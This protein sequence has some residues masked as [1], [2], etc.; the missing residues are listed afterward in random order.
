MVGSAVSRMEGAPT[1]TC[2][3]CRQTRPLDAFTLR[4]DARYYNMCRPCVSEI[5]LLPKNKKR[6]DHSGTERTCYLCRRRLPVGS[7]TRRSNKT[8]FSACKDCNRHVF[9]QRRRARLMQ[10][11][12]SYSVQEWLALLRLFER[13]PGCLRAWT[14]I[15]PIAG[16]PSVVTVDHIVAI[17]KG[18][19]NSIGNIQ[20]LCY[21]CNSR[22][23][24][25]YQKQ[26]PKLAGP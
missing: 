26:P 7:F 18:G 23:G 3:R 21:S 20:P 12:G 22:K 4:L 25:R 2:Y 14:D 6:L 16:R 17:A 1:Q 15:P 13:C 24:D 10:C 19:S 9:A 11:D 5:L 8:F